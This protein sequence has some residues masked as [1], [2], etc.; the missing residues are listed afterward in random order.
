VGLVFV[1]YFLIQRIKVGVTPNVVYFLIKR[2]KVG[3][4]PTVN[5]KN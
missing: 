3:V 4:T 1:T 2:I 5:N